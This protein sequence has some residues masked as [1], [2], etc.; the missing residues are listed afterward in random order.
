MSIRAYISSH[1]RKGFPNSHWIV[2][3][4][5]Q[6]NLISCV[7]CKPAFSIVKSSL[8]FLQRSEPVPI[9]YSCE[10][11]VVS[12]RSQEHSTALLNNPRWLVRA[13]LSSV[14]QLPPGWP[15]AVLHCGLGGSVHTQFSVLKIRV[16]MRADGKSTNNSQEGRT[17]PLKY[18]TI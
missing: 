11:H 1:L 8:F 10:L 9:G 14:P 17:M 12:L 18:W 13:K 16:F 7:R 15:R 6:A 5:V 4:N 3:H 2:C